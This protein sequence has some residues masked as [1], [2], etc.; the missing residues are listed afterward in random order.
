MDYQKKKESK[1]FKDIGYYLLSKPFSK[2]ADSVDVDKYN[3]LKK[4]K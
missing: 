3:D 2:N 4:A 1:L